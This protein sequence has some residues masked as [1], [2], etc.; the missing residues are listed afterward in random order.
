M[1]M[2]IS[3]NRNRT[4]FINISIRE[5]ID[6]RIKYRVGKEP[7]K[8]K[9]CIDRTNPYNKLYTLNSIIT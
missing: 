9:R 1:C 7:Y 2:L 5:G 8:D 4:Q 3:V 6:Y